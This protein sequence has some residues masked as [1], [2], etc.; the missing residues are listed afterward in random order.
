MPFYL[1]G[2]GGVG[3]GEVISPIS[4]LVS[5]QCPFLKVSILIVLF[6]IFFQSTQI[7]ATFLGEKIR[8]IFQKST[9]PKIPPPFYS[10]TSGRFCR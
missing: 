5:E 7:R 8:N 3:L 2:L 10:S 1:E 9:S 6:K 4:E